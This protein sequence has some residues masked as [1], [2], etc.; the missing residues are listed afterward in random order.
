MRD[1]NG[2]LIDQI[3]YGNWDDGLINNNAP[4]PS[5]PFSIARKIDGFNTGNNQNDFLI[6]KN[7][8]P[9]TSNIIVDIIE[10]EEI[11]EMEKANFDYSND[12]VISE[13]F[14]NP[15]G[16]DTEEFIELFNNSEQAVDL[17]GWQIGDESKK[18]FEFLDNRI[19]RAHEYLTIYR[20]E[21]KLAFNNSFDSA[22]L[23]QPLKDKAL[24][25]IKYEKAKEGESYNCANQEAKLPMGS[26][27]SKC[28]W[29]ETITPGKKNI[30]EIINH[31]PEADFDCPEMALIGRPILFDSSDT[32]DIDGD[33]LS[34][35]W[36]FGDLSTNTLAMPEHTF[37]KTGVYAVKLTVSDGQAE[38]EQEKI[39]T[40]VEFIDNIVPGILP[41]NGNDT[42]FDNLKISE[43]IPNPV[44]NDEAEWIEIF[45]SGQ[46]QINLLNWQIDDMEGGSKPFTFKEDFMLGPGQYFLL[47]REESGLALNNTVDQVRLLSPDKE[48]KDVVEYS[49]VSEGETYARGLNDKWFWTASQTPGEEN[50][51]KIGKSP[52]VLGF[53]S[54]GF[55]QSIKVDKEKIITK[56]TLEEIHN[57]E[58]GD[59]LETEGVVAVLPGVLGT[60]YFYIVGSPGIQIY[61]Y[62]KDFPD[63][64]VGDRVAVQGE[65]SEVSGERRVK[66]KIKD[67][68]KVIGHSSAPEPKI[69]ECN[70][71]NDDYLGS[72]LTISGE[73]VENKGS[74]IFLDDGTD[75]LRVYI[76]KDTGINIKNYKEGEIA[77]ISGLLSRTKTGLRLMPRF[78]SD[79][80]KKDVE[81]NEVGQVLGEIAVSNE[82]GITSRNKKLELF[83]YLLVI[84]GAIITVL[85]GLLIKLKKQ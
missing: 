37:F 35:V 7:P 39:I 40:I 22:K 8:T 75:E 21:S 79:I 34:F 45:N 64:M 70:K 20:E 66:T 26:L 16:A 61:N 44:G 6:T 65:I 80:I 69:A 30:F 25:I 36:D 38:S 43:F 84:A 76:K 32:I 78:T 33:E 3:A 17:I 63:L 47:D 4:A 71:I 59:L 18:R 73:I 12:I 1:A 46:E 11:S 82:W 52:S 28:S 81:S 54:S 13:I 67:D 9:G 56:T 55:N 51:I 57:F 68:I 83:K 77:S 62:K 24:Q 41:E 85:A 19:I 53:E 42:F 60:Q 48:I 15:F 74:T 5:D 23:Y 31:L 10:I 72:L 2:K 14:P 50:I 49:G 58:I 27:A 29:S